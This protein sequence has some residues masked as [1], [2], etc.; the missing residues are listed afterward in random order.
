MQPHRAKVIEFADPT[1]HDS[2]DSLFIVPEPGA[3]PLI[4]L[5]GAGPRRGAMASEGEGSSMGFTRL[6]GAGFPVGLPLNPHIPSMANPSHKTDNPAGGPKV[7]RSSIFSWLLGC[8][9]IGTIIG[10]ILGY[11]I[12]PMAD[13]LG[14]GIGGGIV[15]GAMVGFFKCRRNRLEAEE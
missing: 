3:A 8:L 6:T 4:G 9:T 14:Y 7:R 5:A 15:I 2:G 12:G 11:T 10:L 13:W 1:I